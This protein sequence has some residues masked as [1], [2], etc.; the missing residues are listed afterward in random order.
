MRLID[1]FFS[2]DEETESAP[3]ATYEE[4]LLRVFAMLCGGDETVRQSIAACLADTAGYC[5]AHAP[6]F[7]ARGLTY[8]PEGAPWLQWVAAAE[9]ARQA[10]YLRELP[11]DADGAAFARTMKEALDARG[12]VCPLPPESMNFTRLPSVPTRIE[13]F[14]QYAGQAGV[15]LYTADIDSGCY[16][17]GAARIA[18]YALAADA[19][20]RFGLRITSRPDVIRDA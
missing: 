6:L 9:A 1:L 18:D 19:A 14:N 15:T 10:G 17:L 5:A 4:T 2:R 3:A 7:D 11:P 12:L 13:A 20:A 8:R 16:L